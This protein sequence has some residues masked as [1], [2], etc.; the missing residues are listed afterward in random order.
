M[1]DYANAER[2]RAYYLS[3]KGRQNKVNLCNGMRNWNV[4]DYG[5]VYAGAGCECWKQDGKHNCVRCY[6]QDRI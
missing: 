3:H 2:L 6:E 4:C 1:T 5:D